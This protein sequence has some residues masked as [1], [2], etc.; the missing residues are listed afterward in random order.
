[1]W[2]APIKWI[3]QDSFPSS[4]FH[5]VRQIQICALKNINMSHGQIDTHIFFLL[6]F[7]LTVFFYRYC[8]CHAN[9]QLFLAVP[10]IPKF[11]FSSPTSLSLLPCLTT[12][13]T[14]NI[15]QR[16]SSAAALSISYLT[17][18][19]LLLSLLYALLEFFSSASADGF[20]LEFE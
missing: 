19:L 8:R 1:M 11:F 6:F 14:K 9:Q 12:H 13:L 10:S 18:L 17:K 3:L 7:L 2:V 5:L 4:H 15:M 16:S 20:S